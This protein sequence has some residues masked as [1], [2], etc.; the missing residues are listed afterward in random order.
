MIVHLLTYIFVSERE[1]YINHC[2]FIHYATQANLLVTASVMTAISG[3]V[4][5]KK[6]QRTQLYSILGMSN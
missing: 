2:S 6:L 4:Y 3:Y 5:K 1:H